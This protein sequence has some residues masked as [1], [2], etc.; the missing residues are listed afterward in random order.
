[1]RNGSFFALSQIAPSFLSAICVFYNTADNIVVGRFSGDDLALAAVGST[2]GLTALVLMGT[3]AEILDKALLYLRIICIGIP[4][5]FTVF[6]FSW[7]ITGILL[8]VNVFIAYR[9]LKHTVKV[10]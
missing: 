7:T 8:A 3:K 6:P 4:G 9:K 10:Q 1:M 2:T 5:L